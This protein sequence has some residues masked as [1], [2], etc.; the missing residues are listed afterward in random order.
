L[1][2]KTPFWG[3]ALRYGGDMTTQAE[4]CASNCEA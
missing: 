3:V 4:C 2:C 1:H